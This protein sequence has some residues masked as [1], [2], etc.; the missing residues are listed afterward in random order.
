MKKF[1][2]LALL[3]FI[4]MPVTGQEVEVSEYSAKVL[5]VRHPGFRTKITGEAGEVEAFL[6]K[7]LRQLGKLRE[8]NTY[9][10]VSDVTLNGNYFE[11]R[12]FYAQL[13][14]NENAQ[15]F[16]IG[17]DTT[18]LGANSEK[19]LEDLRAYTYDFAINFYKDQVQKEIDES[20]KAE[21]YMEKQFNRLNKDS[22]S[23]QN[24]LIAN[25]REL[26]RLQEAIEANKKEHEDLLQS[27]ET[28]K[29]DLSEAETNLKGIRKTLS[30]QR[31]KKDAIK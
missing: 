23:L 13:G 27:I 5:D 22:V 10:Q 29:N 7:E 8:R 12:M 24:K 31:R 9:F 16:W 21:Q 14:I 1:L 4:I 3:V 20:E 2:S 17:A 19:V 18:G 11:D 30:L 6:K 15:T 28:N 25:E 26:I